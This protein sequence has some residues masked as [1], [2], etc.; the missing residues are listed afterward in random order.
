MGLALLVHHLLKVGA[1]LHELEGLEVAGAAP[2]SSNESTCATAK[3]SAL[4]RTTR[5]D[6]SSVGDEL[7]VP[8]HR[9]RRRLVLLEEHLL[10]LGAW[11][12]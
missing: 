10:P 12:A 8:D 2:H 5:A 7:L 1:V 9:R 4:P 11:A 3:L 6:S